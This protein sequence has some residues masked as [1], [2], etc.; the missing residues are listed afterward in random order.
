MIA[1]SKMRK[2]AIAAVVLTCTVFA[3]IFVSASLLESYANTIDNLHWTGYPI[4]PCFVNAT[5]CGGHLFGTDEVGR[6]VLARL[7]VGARS[8]LGM[9]LAGAV[10]ELT[11]LGLLISRGATRQYRR[12]IRDRTFCR[13]RFLLHG[14]ACCGHRGVDQPRYRVAAAA[15]CYRSY[16]RRA[17]GGESGDLGDRELRYAATLK[18]TYT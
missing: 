18:Q 14:V 7:I 15:R 17:N 16:S 12:A 11:M 4:P 2:R 5:T 10:C 8:S 3:V 9:S 6:D 1:R 13:C